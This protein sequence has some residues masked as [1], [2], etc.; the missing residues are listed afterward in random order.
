[1]RENES[2]ENID[3]NDEIPPIDIS[4]FE[5]CFKN[6]SVESYMIEI[7]STKTEKREEKEIMFK[8]FED[9]FSYVKN[10]SIKS[11]LFNELFIDLDIFLIDDNLLKDIP[12]KIKDYLEE[13]ISKVNEINEEMINEITGTHILKMRCIHQGKTLYYEAIDGNIM[14]M[15]TGEELLT[16]LID[17]IP[18]DKINE[19]ER[20]TQNIRKTELEQLERYILNDPDFHL[21]TN[22][23]LR[24][25]YLKFLKQKYP[26][27]PEILNA[28]G[29]NPRVSMT[30]IE[31][32]WK[33]YKYN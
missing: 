20:E 26:K 17:D 5:N 19:L 16:K 10:E 11:V 28:N 18:T 9:F 27:Y 33:Q 2:I 15:A 25:D 31:K 23:N 32:M 7:N 3:L 4:Y 21:S 8:D 30:F 1:M 24:R 22:A 12:I 14:T 6:I 13:E 29:I